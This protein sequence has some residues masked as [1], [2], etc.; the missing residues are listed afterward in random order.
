[1]CWYF[2]LFRSQ[3]FLLLSI[4]KLICLTIYDAIKKI[5]T[6]T[7]IT[8]ICTSLH[9]ARPL[10]ISQPTREFKKCSHGQSYYPNWCVLLFGDTQCHN[11]NSWCSIM[12]ARTTHWTFISKIELQSKLLLNRVT[13]P[14]ILCPWAQNVGL[15]RVTPNNNTHQLLGII[16]V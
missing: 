1:M 13:W 11:Q 15:C 8:S 2:L 14:Y 10:F 3:Y 4:Q 16:K 6:S 12:S 7:G 9:K 5:T